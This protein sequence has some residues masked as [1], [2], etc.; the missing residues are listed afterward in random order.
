MPLKRKREEEESEHGGSQQGAAE[1]KAI[2]SDQVI[3]QPRFRLAALLAHVLFLQAASS[4]GKDAQVKSKQVWLLSSCI[5]R[6]QHPSQLM[7]SA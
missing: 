4:S 7:F 1:E 3:H 2:S 5:V 6:Y